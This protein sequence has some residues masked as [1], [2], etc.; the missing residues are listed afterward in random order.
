EEPAAERAE[1]RLV[2]VDRLPVPV[3]EGEE[4]VAERGEERMALALGRRVDRHDAE[5]ALGA[6]ADVRHLEVADDHL[7]RV[8]DREERLGPLAA[9]RG[10]LDHVLREA[11]VVV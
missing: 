7:E 5:L 4:A 6:R 8:A 3:L 9:G 2:E 1:A 10:A 11:A